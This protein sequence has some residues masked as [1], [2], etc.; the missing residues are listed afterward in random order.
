MAVQDAA[1][2]QNGKETTDRPV[3]EG[4]EVARSAGENTRQLARRRPPAG[5]DFDPMAATRAGYLRIARSFK[6]AGSYYSAI[7]AYEDILARYPDTGTINAV[8]EELVAL[9]ETL[10]QQGQFYT[11]LHLFQKLDDALL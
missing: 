9:A 2:Q 7:Y 4:R 5:Y 11:A 10:V 8:T 6:N 1:Q 3:Q